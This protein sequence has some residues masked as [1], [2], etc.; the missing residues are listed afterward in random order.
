MVER[1]SYRRD[2]AASQPQSL[3]D[4]YKSTVLRAPSQPLVHIPQT[5]TETTGLAD[6]ASI[7]AI[8]I[9]GALLLFGGKKG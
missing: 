5:V 3:F 4:P 8:A 9:G 6:W 7:G 1:N 2:D